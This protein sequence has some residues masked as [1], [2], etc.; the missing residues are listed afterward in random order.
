ME[1][2]N[3]SISVG[4]TWNFI[5][6]KFRLYEFAFRKFQELLLKQLVFGSLEQQGHVRNPNVSDQK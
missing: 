1:A 4:P 2:T 5:L 6:S 3:F